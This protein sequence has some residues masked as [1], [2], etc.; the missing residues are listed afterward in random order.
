MSN[1]LSTCSHFI[2]LLQLWDLLCRFEEVH[3]FPLEV[4]VTNLR[5]VFPSYNPRHSNTIIDLMHGNIKVQHHDCDLIKANILYGYLQPGPRLWLELSQ[6]VFPR[7]ICH[8][9]AHSAE[10]TVC[11][12]SVKACGTCS[13]SCGS[14]SYQLYQSNQDGWR[15][16]LNM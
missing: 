6:R 14:I 2:F 7:G 16:K 1:S 12:H 10:T 15:Q 13:G 3:S 11:P 8:E 5:L 9:T 4:F